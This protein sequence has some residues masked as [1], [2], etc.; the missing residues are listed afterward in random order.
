MPPPTV[1]RDRSTPLFDARVNSNCEP[2]RPP[3]PL[4]DDFIRAE[5]QRGWKGES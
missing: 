2:G 4:L 5:E 1:I 3:L